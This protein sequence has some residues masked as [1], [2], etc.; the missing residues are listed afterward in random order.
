MSVELKPDIYHILVTENTENNQSYRKHIAFSNADRIKNWIQDKIKNPQI[1][2]NSLSPAAKIKCTDHSRVNNVISMCGTSAI[3]IFYINTPYLLKVVALV[4]S[5]ASIFL[6]NKLAKAVESSKANWFETI[7]VENCLPYLTDNSAIEKDLKCYK[8]SLELENEELPLDEEEDYLSKEDLSKKI[9]NLKKLSFFISQ[10]ES[11]K[12]CINFFLKNDQNS[13]KK[14]TAGRDLVFNT[15]YSAICLLPL[16]DISVI[17]N[18]S[19]MRKGDMMS[20]A[21]GVLTV[22]LIALSILFVVDAVKNT[23]TIIK[24]DPL[25][26]VTEDEKNN[27]LELLEKEKQIVVA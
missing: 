3:A 1:A 16:K 18:V 2:E 13:S 20:V 6:Y 14:T 7:A 8:K 15:F 21:L 25:N 10:S 11:I 26:T 9:E 22:G 19:G 23:L 5:I 24:P 17:K 12:K 27:L 4:A